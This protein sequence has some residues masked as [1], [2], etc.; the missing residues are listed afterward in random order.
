M[1]NI[2]KVTFYSANPQL[3]EAG[4]PISNLPPETVE[5]SWLQVE[6]NV[7]F[8][9]SSGE[10]LFTELTDPS[11]P[12]SIRVVNG[13]YFGSGKYG[14]LLAI[15]YTYDDGTDGW[16]KTNQPSGASAVYPSMMNGNWVKGL[17][18]EQIIAHENWQGKPLIGYENDYIDFTIERI[19]PD[20]EL[21]LF[22]MQKAIYIG[23]DITFDY[24]V[25]DFCEGT[26]TG[27]WTFDGATTSITGAE[28]SKTFS[29]EEVGM[30]EVRLTV[31]NA[32]GQTVTKTA[33][34]TVQER[35]VLACDLS[36]SPTNITIRMGQTAT[37]NAIHPY[38]EVGEWIYD[39]SLVVVEKENKKIVVSPQALGSYEIRYVVGQCEDVST[40]YVLEPPKE[41]EY[42]DPEEPAPPL[43][44][45][46]PPD[47]AGTPSLAID[48]VD[49][50][51]PIPPLYKYPNIMK[52]NVRYRGHRESEKMLNDHQEQIYDIR[53]LYKDIDSLDKMKDITIDTWFHGIQNLSI[54]TKAV[55]NANEPKE[56]QG[57]LS[58]SDVDSVRVLEN[59]VVQLSGNSFEERIVGIYGIKRQMQE[60]DERIAEAERRYRD[61]EN[62]YK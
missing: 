20:I 39:M 52:R 45:D 13:F 43:L 6:N 14:A 58:D 29:F 27:Q 4:H 40:L 8:S 28:G 59:D 23:E 25:V 30:Q 19:V 2:T 34:I 62:A 61:Y 55:V 42:E 5:Q 7:G 44:P 36:L 31:Q 38:A 41:G 51:R 47:T 26:P 37:F 12:E 10:S 57:I 24:T 17:T 1:P 60:L 49:A 9:L 15:Q 56:I 11:R 48:L 3:D 54:S 35:P 32:C 46:T 16:V 21:T 18:Y 50:S 22:P 33:I 53:Q